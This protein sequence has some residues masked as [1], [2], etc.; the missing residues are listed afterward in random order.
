MYNINIIK[1]KKEKKKM[2]YNYYDDPVGE[3]EKEAREFAKNEMSKLDLIDCMLEYFGAEKYLEWC[4][5]QPTFRDKFMYDIA[6][7]ESIYFIN[8]YTEKR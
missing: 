4:L 7:G 1:Q 3:T 8:N 5:S 6:K 2:W